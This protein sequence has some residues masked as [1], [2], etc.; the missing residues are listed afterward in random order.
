VL[1]TGIVSLGEGE[2]SFDCTFND[3]SETGARIA[4]GKNAQVPAEFY[5]VNVRDRC[6]YRAKLVWSD[7]AEIGVTFEKTWPLAN[8]DPKLAY[9]KR[10]WLAK[11][12][13]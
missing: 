8:L 13:R 1:L 5:L 2:R 6:A 10:L 11:A 7:G 3:L 12:T 9:L 4:T